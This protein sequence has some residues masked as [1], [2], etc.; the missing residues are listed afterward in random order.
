MH[1]PI[2][3]VLYET[4]CTTSRVPTMATHSRDKKKNG[5]EDVQRSPEYFLTPHQIPRI[6]PVVG[7]R[8]RV[9]DLFRKML[10]HPFEA[11]PRLW[12]TLILTPVFSIRVP[13]PFIAKNHLKDRAPQ[14]PDVRLLVKPGP[15]PHLPVN[16]APPG[17]LL[18]GQSTCRFASGEQKG[19]V[20]PLMF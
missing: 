16:S 14:C 8:I 15:S 5:I 18:R 11:F 13:E 20:H 9:Q 6:E 7:P 3:Y 12:M 4:K 2:S 19:P 1:I 10:C 17:D